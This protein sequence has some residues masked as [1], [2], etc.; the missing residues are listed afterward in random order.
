MR[1][2]PRLESF[3]R[4]LSGSSIPGLELRLLVGWSDI[5]V[6]NSVRVRQKAG[7]MSRAISSQNCGYLDVPS[8]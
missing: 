2:F 5:E 7:T 4:F 1:Q 6:G 8:V 3:C